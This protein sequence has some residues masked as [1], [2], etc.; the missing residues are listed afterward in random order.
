MRL[1]VGDLPL[2]SAHHCSAVSSNSACGTTAFT[3]L[4]AAAEAGLDVIVVDHHEAEAA[5]P[6]AVAVVN[7]KR[8]EG[9]TPDLAHL[10]GSR[11]RRA[12]AFGATAHD[13]LRAVPANHE[14]RGERARQVVGL[15]GNAFGIERPALLFDEALQ[16]GERVVD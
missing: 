5:L 16:A 12:A 9:G 3:A 15:R 10:A 6:E 2:I 13:Q 11:R 4:E 14:K 8:I 1:A 7:P